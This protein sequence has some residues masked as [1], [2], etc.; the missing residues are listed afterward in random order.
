[1]EARVRIAAVAA[2]LAALAAC[3]PSTVRIDVSPE[4]GDRARYEYEIDATITRS[5]DDGPPTT[6]EIATELV[7][8]QEVVALRGRDVEVEVMLRRDG[9]A[10][11]TARVV[12][13][14]GGTIRGIELV[15]GLSG[16]ALG[17]S[18]LGALLPPSTELPGGELTLGA[19]WS[20]DDGPVTG[21]SRLA[22]LGVVDGVEVAV[23]DT[24]L[25]QEVDDAVAAGPSA[26]RLQGRLRSETS[27]AYDIDGGEIRR[28]SSRSTGDLRARIEPP[29]GI[30]ASAALATITYDITVR[31]RR[32][33]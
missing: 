1:M 32:L 21:R 8:Q 24:R 4:V 12:L 28:S 22:R 26:A 2:G 14:R 18:Q 13:D 23:V 30:T 9:A 10:E 11:R 17:L 6:T 3:S 16:D 5:L 7:A 15:E 25:T 20:V 19:R 27:A 31:V 33:A 29:P